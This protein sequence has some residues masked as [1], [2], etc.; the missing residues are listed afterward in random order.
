MIIL[1]MFFCKR[2]MSSRA[3]TVMAL[4]TRRGNP[5]TQLEAY[6]PQPD[7]INILDKHWETLEVYGLFADQSCQPFEWSKAVN[8]SVHVQCRQYHLIL[9]KLEVE[10]DLQQ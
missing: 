7:L 4:T 5:L 9:R 2:W 10:S 1:L 8:S 3:I 6:F